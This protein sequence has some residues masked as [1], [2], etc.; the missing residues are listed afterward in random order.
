MWKL[1]SSSDPRALKI[2]DGTHEF[3]AFGPHYSRRTP[4]S[5][6]FTGCGKEIVLL[7]EDNCAVWAVVYQRTPQPRGT[8]GVKTPYVWRN[9]LFR[10]LGSELSSRLIVSA[11]AE[12]YMK[13]KEKYR[14]L[15]IEILRT[16]IAPNK[17]KSINPGY[18]YKIAGFW[19]HRVVNGKVFL[20]APC[21]TRVVLGTCD[22]CHNSK[23]GPNQTKSVSS[24]LMIETD[25]RKE[26]I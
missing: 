2:V 16:E 17:I 1:S 21:M 4:G 8:H 13:W 23:W 26:E 18:S 24:I 5:K 15:P 9:M 19:N 22:C 7:S 14:S 3:S 20:D 11:V 10:N 25:P 6:T 12:T